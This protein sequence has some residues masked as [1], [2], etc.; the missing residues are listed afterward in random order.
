MFPRLVS[1]LC[2]LCLSSSALASEE[3]S[4]KKS[5]PGLLSRT[6]RTVNIFD[7][8]PEQPDEKGVV[9]TKFLTLTMQL[10][11]LPLKLSEAR[12]L[13]VSLL[14]ANKSK[15]FVQLEFPTTQRIEVL[16]RD[17]AGKMV[18]QWS[19]DQAFA[20]VGSYAVINPGERLEYSASVSTRDMAAGKEYVVEG[21]FP[22]F[23]ELR[24][25]TSIVPEK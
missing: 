22:H 17:K 20:S 3:G 1:V 15:K 16:V 13:K 18:T 14:L 25:R 6:W 7:R 19:E 8:S 9:R 12:Q 21:F 23:E 24:A 2:V 11:P 5:R 10:A 4:G